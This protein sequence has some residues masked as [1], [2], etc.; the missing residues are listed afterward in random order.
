VSKWFDCDR[1]AVALVRYVS[2]EMGDELDDEEGEQ[3]WSDDDAAEEQSDA[4]RVELDR[5]PL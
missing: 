5:S 4:D 2:G 1:G 3:D